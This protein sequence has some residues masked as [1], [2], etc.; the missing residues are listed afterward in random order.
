MSKH[1]TRVVNYGGGT[2]STALMILAAQEGVEIDVIPF[3]DT[4]SEMPHT[5]EYVSMFSDW[6]VARGLPAITVVRWIRKEGEDKGKFVAL[7]ESCERLKTLPSRAFGFSG[8]TV[9]WKQQPIDSFLEAHPLCAEAFSRGEKVERWIGFDAD[10]PA[11]AQ[12][13]ELKN[14]TDTRWSWKAPLYERKIGRAECEGIITRAG[15]DLPG[16]SACWM[17]PSSKKHEIVQLRRRYPEL[18]ARALQIE[19]NADLKSIKGLGG[20]L[21]WG[22]F[23]G[24]R[25]GPNRSRFHAVVT[26]G[27][28]TYCRLRARTPRALRTTGRT[29]HEALGGTHGC[30]TDKTNA[31]G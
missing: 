17:C 25:A 15:L 29:R 31:Q 9:K 1:V 14:I 8:C 28:T 20:R 7:H 19:A 3:A 5:Y 27:R 2:N 16:K 6:L 12:R 21:N 30:S 4:G 11:R 18:A 23:C 24:R 26:T 22:E 13:Q 10:E